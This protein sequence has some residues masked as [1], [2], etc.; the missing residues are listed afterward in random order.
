MILELPSPTPSVSSKLAII[1][2]IG[3]DTV[4]PL[5]PDAMYD[6]SVRRVRI[7]R[8]V[9]RTKITPDSAR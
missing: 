6:A 5:P 3:A 4:G 9:I 2:L 1:E 8:R 7:I